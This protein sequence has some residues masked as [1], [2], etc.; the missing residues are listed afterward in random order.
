M[1][2]FEHLLKDVHAIWSFSQSYSKL[3]IV[4]LRASS[5]DLFVS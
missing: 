5:R 2:K 4:I 1:I 3:R